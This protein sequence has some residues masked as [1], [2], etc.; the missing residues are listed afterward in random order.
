M[1]PRWTLFELLSVTLPLAGGAAAAFL[2]ARGGGAW[3]GASAA[4]ACFAGAAAAWR[5]AA[6]RH[7]RE[8]ETAAA[9]RALAASFEEAARL[10]GVMRAGFEAAT[11]AMLLTDAEGVVLACNAEARRFF[12]RDAEAIVGRHMEELFTHAEVL[13]RHRK[14]LSGE[15]GESRVRIGVGLAGEPR[16]YEVRACPVPLPGGASGALTTVRDVTDL[17]LAVQLKTDF[18]ANASHELRTPLASIKGAV[19]TLA[20]GAWEDAAMRERLTRMMHTNVARLEELIA[21]LLDLSRLE[22][23]E[24]PITESSVDVPALVERLRE[25]FD[26][27]LSERRLT[28]EV[29]LDPRLT[30]L[31]SD[32]KLLDLIL[33]NLIDNA[34]KF[35]YEQTAIRVVGEVMGNGRAR[36][37][38]IDRGIGIPLGQQRR[39]FERF[40]QVDASRAGADGRP[41]GTGLGLAIVKHA[42]AALGGAVRAESVW[43]SGTEMI[44]EGVGKVEAEPHAA[45]L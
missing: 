17:A 43:K 18:V 25:S 44:V 39:V 23:P 35:A 19:E 15:T 22:T 36:L 29:S 21:D 11:G 40:Y 9:T 37:R 10:G 38:V 41:R 14:A 27:A 6:H 1:P 20:D 28:L 7:A 8:R 34:V 26:R 33:R 4:A 31:T 30:R 3:V 42:A 5:S 24:A 2:V 12:S 13:L 32:P 16:T 45:S